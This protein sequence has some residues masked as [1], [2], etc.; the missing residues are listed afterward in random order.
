MREKKGDTMSQY[1]NLLVVEQHK[2]RAEEIANDVA[3]AVERT[4]KAA[5]SNNKGSTV[6]SL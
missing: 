4:G 5:L 3:D 2:G 1:K 6:G